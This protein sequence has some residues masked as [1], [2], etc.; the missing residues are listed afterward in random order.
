M[1]IISSNNLPKGIDSELALWIYNGLDCAATGLA[2]T[3]MRKQSSPEAEL[4][5][6]FVTGMRAPAL[7]MMMRGIR[8]DMEQRQRF[9]ELY[10]K[11]S[12]V[13]Q[14]ILNQFAHAVWGKGL[15]PASP[16][17]MKEFLYGTM[18]LPEQ[19]KSA[20]GERK[21]STDR[22][23]LEKLSFH[24]HAQPIVNTVLAVREV[25]KKLSFLR[26]GIDNDFR[27]RTSFNVVGTETGRWSSSENPFGTGTNQQ[28]ITDEL[29]QMFVSDEGYKLGYFDKDQAESRAVAY[30]SG[31]EGYINACNSG[32]LHTTV[33]RMV[34]QELPWTG[35]LEKDKEIAERPFYRH[36]SYRDMAKRGGHGTNYYGTPFTM[37]KH[38][39]VEVKLMENFQRAYFK[40][41]PGIRAWHHKVALA[42]QTKGY[43]I[44]ALGRKRNFLG[45]RFDDSTL[46]EAIAFEPQSVVGELLNLFLYRVWRSS[47]PIQVLAQVHDAILIQYPQELET[48]L[49]QKVIA[50]GRTEVQFPCGTMVIP[51]S[52]QTGWNWAKYKDSNPYGMKKFKGD[53]KRSAPTYGGILDWK[54]S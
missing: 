13:L 32:D 22:D 44:T 28:N 48:E 1:Q 34:W 39:K 46:R 36:F 38:L 26:A 43:L 27:C 33:C 40:A 37:A 5:Y 11:Q 20:K 50:L 31:D 17:Q 54:V 15:N 29:R 2:W 35:D 49:V 6:S 24:F 12:L 9:I 45:R 47:L 7:E 42:L 14:D 52:A 41:F 8:I 53:D 3:G 23:A 30:I 16:K 21:L 25:D 4:S 51:V 18:G 19:F 10:S